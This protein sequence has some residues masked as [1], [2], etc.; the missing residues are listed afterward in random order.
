MQPAVLVRGAAV[1]AEAIRAGTGTLTASTSAAVGTTSG[2]RVV[3]TS[4][5]SVAVA[6]VGAVGTGVAAGA[7]TGGAAGAQAFNASTAAKIMQRTGA[8]I[9]LDCMEVITNSAS[10]SRFGAR[11]PTCPRRRRNLGAHTEKR[12]S[13]RNGAV[14]HIV[15]VRA[16]A[17]GPR[18]VS[19]VLLHRCSGT[20][21]M[22]AEPLRTWCA[23]T[24]ASQRGSV[25]NGLEEL[26]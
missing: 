8:G 15:F 5:T 20:G 17:L 25:R 16:S 4:L 11:S 10:E 9:V 3:R 7:D 18:G 14:F 13:R 21:A 24:R 12:R 6:I 23:K 26:S 19:V 1:H 2:A 22:R